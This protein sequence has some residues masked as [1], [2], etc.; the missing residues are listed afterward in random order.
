M[1]S[2]SLIMSNMIKVQSYIVAP[3]HRYDNIIN[4]QKELFDV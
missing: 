2:H 1:L 4:E 3:V